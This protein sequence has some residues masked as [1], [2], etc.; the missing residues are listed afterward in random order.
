MF[1]LFHSYSQGNSSSTIEGISSVK[2]LNL[3]LD[4][5]CKADI[6]FWS[7]SEDGSVL[8]LDGLRE[9]GI[10]HCIHAHYGNPSVMEFEEVQPNI[11]STYF[12][13]A[14]DKKSRA[15]SVDGFK[16]SIPKD[17]ISATLTEYSMNAHGVKTLT[18][19]VDGHEL[20]YDCNDT[21]LFVEKLN[22]YSY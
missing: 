22:H 5:L 16:V 12:L 11:G 21:M 9:L 8:P 3:E 7:V 20:V 6:D 13:L 15:T 19:E 17:H 18:F 2:E 1:S 10:R 14:D 4:K